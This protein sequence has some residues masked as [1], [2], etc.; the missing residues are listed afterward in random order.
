[1]STTARRDTPINIRAT[2]EERQLIDRAA[3]A[4]GKSRTDFMLE[5]ARNAAEE[6]LLDRVYIA[7]DDA[8][9]ETFQSI[10]EDPPRPTQALRDL[11]AERKKPGPER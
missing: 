3:K 8:T 7:L 4:L 10:L 2:A 1:M 5:S 6:V 11:F 9:W